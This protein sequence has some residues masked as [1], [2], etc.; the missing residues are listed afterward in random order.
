MVNDNGFLE[1]EAALSRIF[2]INSAFSSAERW[3]TKSDGG[4]KC[5]YFTVKHKNNKKIYFYA[6]KIM[7]FSL[8]YQ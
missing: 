3:Q 8:V 6:C 4:D 5:V 7:S 1:G 2:V